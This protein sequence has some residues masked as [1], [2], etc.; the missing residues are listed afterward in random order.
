MSIEV[1]IAPTEKKMVEVVEISGSVAKLLVG[2]FDGSVRIAPPQLPRPKSGEWGELT[3]A[4]MVAELVYADGSL[5]LLL[6]GRSWDDQPEF[7]RMRMRLNDPAKF[8]LEDGSELHT[9]LCTWTGRS[10]RLRTDP[11]VASFKHT[12][13]L[14]DWHWSS[15]NAPCAW[16]GLLDGA[17]VDD[18]NL[19]ILAGHGWSAKH[20]YVRANYDIYV[21]TPQSGETIVVVDTKGVPL[22][23]QVMASDV[24]ALE[25]AMGRPLG[26]DYLLGLDGAHNVV[27]AAGIQFGNR[28]PP[29][30]RCRCPVAG[31][32][33]LYAPKSGLIAEHNWVPLFAS[34]VA[35]RL[36]ADGVDSPLNIAM[37]AYL[38]SLMGDIHSNYLLAQVA[39]EAFCS[40]VVP[41]ETHTLVKSSAAWLAFVESHREEI[42]AMAVDAE[43]ARK[44]VSKVQNAQHAPSGDRVH[45]ALTHFGIEA[46]EAALREVIRRNSA[47]HRYVMTKES[48]LVVQDVADRL[49]IVQTLLVSVVAKYVGFR[50]PIVGWEWINGRHKVPDWWK[51]ERSAEAAVAFDAALEDDESREPE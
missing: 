31:S 5:E 25:F 1:Q 42:G 9:R 2:V 10:F 51:W 37:G 50:G 19:T 29:D 16:V 44:L 15:A 22:D 28:H 39:L 17:K 47:A 49:A 45:V 41:A 14:V 33:D 46:P 40:A 30:P 43:A 38:N 26:L 32:R 11:P 23:H 24:A 3:L 34:L 6:D 13:E 8:V 12:I 21:V 35:K 36:E 4:E 7:R 48:E 18:A 20:L 27:S